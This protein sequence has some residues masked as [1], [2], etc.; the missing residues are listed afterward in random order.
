MSHVTRLVA[1]A[2]V[3]VIVTVVAMTFVTRPATAQSSV[4]SCWPFSG[5]G[6]GSQEQDWMTKQIA[7]G[8]THFVSIDKTLCSW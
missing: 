1:T 3:T 2:V 5:N 6:G 7:S 4:V 8:R